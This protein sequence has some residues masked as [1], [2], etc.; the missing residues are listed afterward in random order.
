MLK[1]NEIPGIDAVSL[2]QLHALGIINVKQLVKFDPAMLT[3]ELAKANATLEISDKSPDKESV[4]NWIAYAIDRVSFPSSTL[5]AVEQPYLLTEVNYE[6]NE[7]VAYILST[8]PF[9]IPLPGRLLMENQLPVNDVPAGLLLSEYSDDLDVRVGPAV[10]KSNATDLPARRTRLNTGQ[11]N[12]ENPRREIDISQLKSISSEPSGR[13]MRVPK[14]KANADDD[15]VALIRAPRESTNQGKDPNS[16]NYV[17]GVLHTHPWG[18]RIGAV[19]CLVLLVNIPFA[20]CS[21]ILLLLSQEIPDKFEWV[22]QWILIFPA[23]LPLLGIIYL[24]W[25]FH[26]KCRICTQKLFVAKGALKHVKAHRFPGMGY[27]VPLC[28]HLLIFS[29]FRCSSCGTPVRLK[30]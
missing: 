22:P 30:K 24:I 3:V 9:A 18:L 21:A 4:A 23:A 13:R 2:E 25:G 6:A 27:V 11:T 29:W 16:R 1:L 12:T 15:R 19:S 8:A 17:R 7:E 26:G 10:S 28:I 20:I 14:S 5:Q